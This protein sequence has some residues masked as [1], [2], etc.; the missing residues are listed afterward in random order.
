MKRFLFIFLVFAFTATP[1]VAQDVS[2][3]PSPEK[4]SVTV[5][6]ESLRELKEQFTE[7]KRKIALQDSL[8]KEQTRQIGLWEQRVHQDS[9]ILNLT[10]KRLDIKQER[11]DMRDDRIKRLERNKTWEEIK[12]YIWAGGTLVIGFLL[13]SAGS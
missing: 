11:I 10:K 4:D 12:K 9:L 6:V 7:Q 13:G 2:E 3:N 8:I 1:A 5:S